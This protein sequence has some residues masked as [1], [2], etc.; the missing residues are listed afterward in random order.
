M[1]TF[2]NK[3][4][5]Q[6][7]ELKSYLQNVLPLLASMKPKAQLELLKHAV[8]PLTISEIDEIAVDLA[9]SDVICHTD[10]LAPMDLSFLKS[11]PHAHDTVIYRK[12]SWPALV[13]ADPRLLCLLKEVQEVDGSGQHYCANLIWVRSFKPRLTNLVGWSVSAHPMLGSR[14]AYDCA[15][16]KIYEALPDCRDCACI[17]IE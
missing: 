14:Q 13:K 9:N 10:A 7:D 4:K 8:L 1:P 11:A 16:T 3:T 17:R 15:Y 12:P 2:T 5:K 6:V